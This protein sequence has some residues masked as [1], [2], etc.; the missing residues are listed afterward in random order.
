MAGSIRSSRTPI[1]IRQ[2]GTIDYRD[3]WQVQRELADTRVAGG[4]DTLLLLEHPPV[5]TAGRRT[6]PHERPINDSAGTPVLDTDRGGKITW[7][8]PGQLVGYPIIGL[9]EPLDVVNYVRRLEE[10]LIKVCTDLGLEAGRVDG[11]SGVW[12]AADAGRPARKIA[13]IG[14]RVSRATTLHGFALN[15]DCDLGAFTAIVPCGITDAGVTS[16]TAELGRPVTVDDVRSAVAEAVCDALDGVLP[17]GEHPV[18]R[19]ASAM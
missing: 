9:A 12:L 11:R 19:V 18:A 17:V 2:L 7:H 6:E 16:L 1:D 14:V 3:A 15:C 13:A 10:S 4:P 5:Y 8:G